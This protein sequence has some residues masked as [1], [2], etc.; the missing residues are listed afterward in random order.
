MKELSACNVVLPSIVCLFMRILGALACLP[1]EGVASG[2]W[3][4]FCAASVLSL[5]LIWGQN[6]SP[7]NLSSSA[8]IG[9]FLLGLSVGLPLALSV[10]AY[11]ALGDFI[12]SARGQ[13]MSEMYSPLNGNS[14]SLTSSLLQHYSFSLLLFT[15]AL[16]VLVSQVFKSMQMQS[17]GSIAAENYSDLGQHFIHMAIYSIYHFSFLAVPFAVIFL[18]LDLCMIFLAKLIPGLSLLSEM[19]L[20][21]SALAFCAIYYLLQRPVY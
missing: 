9:D 18:C 16:D 13:N 17:L 21:K 11:S 19:F 3:L 5:T 8:L 10:Q 2:W 4:R 6:V 20:A 12:D 14:S 7:I 1:F 15:G